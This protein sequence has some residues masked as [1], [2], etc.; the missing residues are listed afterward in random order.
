MFEKGWWRA[1]AAG[2]GAQG[3]PR[4][5]NVGECAKL[6]AQGSGD[7]RSGIFF[8]KKN[9]DPVKRHSG[10]MATLGKGITSLPLPP[11]LLSHKTFVCSKCVT[12]FYVTC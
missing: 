8:E 4:S 11:S 1:N 3:V 10:K 6:H 9:V 5:C 2:G 12:E 7:G